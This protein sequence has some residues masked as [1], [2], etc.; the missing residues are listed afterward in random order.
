MDLNPLLFDFLLE[1]KYLNIDG[2][3][4]LVECL[5]LKNLL[6]NKFANLLLPPYEI[7]VW[8]KHFQKWSNG[9]HVKLVQLHRVGIQW[10]LHLLITILEVFII[11]QDELQVSASGHWYISQLVHCPNHSPLPLLA[12]IVRLSAVH[13]GQRVLP[14]R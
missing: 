6:I 3:Q 11:L 4:L 5:I 1:L 12:L 14:I 10:A 13:L 2:A 7:L 8:R 9:G